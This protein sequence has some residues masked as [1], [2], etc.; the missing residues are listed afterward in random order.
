MMEAYLNLQRTADHLRTEELRILRPLGLTP[1]QYNVLRI[2]RGAGTDGLPS[3]EIGVRM[4]TRVPDVTRLVDRLE[5]AGLVERTRS[6]SDR[7]VVLVRIGKKGLELLAGID[8]PMKRMP[9]KLMGGLGTAEL[10]KLNDLLV[11]LRGAQ[12]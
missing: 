6:E 8:E 9:D 12:D 7:R 5:A 11:R 3:A 10:R 2:L 1:Q 4:V